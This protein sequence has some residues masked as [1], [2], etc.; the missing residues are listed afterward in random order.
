MSNKI[1]TYDRVFNQVESK[2]DIDNP[3]NVDPNGRSVSLGEMISN[4]STLSSILVYVQLID[5]TANIVMSRDLDLD[6][7]SSLDD[8]VSIHKAASGTVNCSGGLE[9]TSDDGTTWKILVDNLG[10]LSTSL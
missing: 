4:D 1:Y 6:E 3:N 8:I 9:V 5:T 2:W 10:V 7:K